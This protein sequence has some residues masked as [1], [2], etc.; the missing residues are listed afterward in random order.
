MRILIIRHADPDYEIDGLTERGKLEAAALA[1]RLAKESIT[2]IYCSTLG[3]ARRT[4]EPTLKAKGMTAKYCEWLRE[5]SYASVNLPYCDKPRI[6][7]D[8]FPSFVETCKGLY[9]PTEWRNEPFIK[10]GDVLTHYDSVC[11]ELD[12]VIEKHGYV[13]EGYSYKAVK[14]NHDT[15][16]L[17]CHYGVA[18]V[19]LAHLTNSSPYTFWQNTVKLP[20]S[21]TTIYTEERRDGIASMRASGIGDVGH[22]YAEGLEPSF[23]AR[24]CECFADDTRHD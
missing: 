24:F 9:S 17:F 15:I 13:R 19:L 2:E 5:F 18:S 10:E 7:W 12:Q 21:V 6:C 14:P 4:A 1:K 20:S 22:L 3:R 16:A 8:L 11:H 23:A